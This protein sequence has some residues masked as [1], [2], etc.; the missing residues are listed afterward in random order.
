MPRGAQSLLVSFAP[1]QRCNNRVESNV[2][3]LGS[4]TS[5]A[6]FGFLSLISRA[7]ALFLG[8]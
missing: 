8:P 2:G 1:S 6:F 7:R 3:W 4:L 5:L